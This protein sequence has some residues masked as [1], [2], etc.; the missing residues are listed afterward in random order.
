MHRV[1]RVLLWVMGVAFVAIGVMHMALG[2]ASV[3]GEGSAGATIDSRERF[4]AAI[5]LGFGLAWVWVARRSPIPATAVRWL[6]AIFLLGG[7]GRVLSFVIYGW[8]HWLQIGESVLEL[9]LPLLFFWLA[10][11]DEQSPTSS[12]VAS[13]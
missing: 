11:A 12:R 6:S 4:Y 2:I 10:A 9:I 1:L 7:F 3:P 13:R 8:P 5:F